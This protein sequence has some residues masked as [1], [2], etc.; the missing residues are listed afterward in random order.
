MLHEFLTIHRDEI[1]A[2]TRGKVAARIA[3]RPSQDELDN[4]VPLFLDQLAETLRGEQ[5]SATRMTSAEMARSAARQGGE[6]RAAGFT[7]GQVVHGYGDVCQAVTELAIDLELPISADEF[8]TLNR[9]LDEAIAQAVTEY[10]RQRDLTLSDRG[11]ERLGFFAHELRNLLSN[12]LLA[13]EVLK[14]GTV[15]IGGSTGGVLGRNLVLL[16]DLIERSLAEVRLEAGVHHRERVPL[17]ELM[18][19]VEVSAEIEAQ[20]RGFQVTITPVEPGV[21]IDVDR[22]LIAAAIANLLQNAFKFSRPNGHIVLR[23]DTASAAGRVLIEVED[24]CGGLP[25][26]KADDL[27]RP[28]EQ[29]SADRSG[30]GLGL[31]I[32]RE[33]VQTNGGAIRLRN[34]PG[35]GCIFTIDLPRLSPGSAAATNELAVVTIN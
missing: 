7:V 32:A 29:R 25:P 21:A 17:T 18:E 5:E 34:L 20:S 10:A 6:L 16:R 27:F 31:A 4:G 24:E 22:Q 13:F 23:T 14:S 9:C 15:G 28:F 26:G 3:P 11:T 33:S 12:A 2:L 19:E 35:R 1:I 8:K 30:L